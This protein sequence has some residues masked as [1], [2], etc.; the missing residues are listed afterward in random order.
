MILQSN[1]VALL[2]LICS[3]PFVG[4]MGKPKMVGTTAC[5]PM[6]LSKFEV[7]SSPS[8]KFGSQNHLYKSVT[9][10]YPKD[11]YRA[12]VIGFYYAD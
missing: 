3:I 2:T 7:F 1:P 8:S 5:D 10:L 6:P 4:A 12:L 11:K 9:D